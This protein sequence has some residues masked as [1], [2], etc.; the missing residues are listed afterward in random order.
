M[1]IRRFS[2]ILILT[3]AL[4]LVFVSAASAAVKLGVI[5][6]PTGNGSVNVRSGPSTAKYVR[7]WAFHGDRVIL[8]S[9]GKYWDNIR[10]VKTGV[11]GYVYNRYIVRMVDVTTLANW[12]S[13]ARIKTKYASSTVCLRTGPGTSYDVE[14]YLSPSNALAVLGKYGSWYE[15]QLVPGLTTGYVYKDYIT[16]GAYGVTTA[17][18]NLRKSGSSSSKVLKTLPTGANIIILK[19]GSKWSKVT[20]SGKTGYIYNKYIGV[21]NLAP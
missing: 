20:C 2:R 6:M 9:T 11:T 18:V 15:V 16:N 17:S 14:D 13:M 5:Q 1:N 3:L 19:I 7:G 12:G 8:L 4:A 21:T 10:V